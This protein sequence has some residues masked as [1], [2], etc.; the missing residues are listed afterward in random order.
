MENLP[1]EILHLVGN[2]LGPADIAS[3]C[4]TSRNLKAKSEAQLYKSLK[5]TVSPMFTQMRVHDDIWQPGRSSRSDSATPRR[6]RQ[7]ERSWNPESTFHRRNSA[8][9]YV[10][11]ISLDTTQSQHPDSSIRLARSVLRYLRGNRLRGF[12]WA[13][14]MPFPNDI[15]L[16][17]AARHTYLQHIGLEY[18]GAKA[19]LV[20]M[21][22]DQLYLRRIT[23]ISLRE[24]IDPGCQAELVGRLENVL[25]SIPVLKH[26]SLYLQGVDRIPSMGSLTRHGTT[27]ESLTVHCRTS[28]DPSTILYW[29]KDDLRSLN[30]YMRTLQAL[31]CDV[32]WSLKRQW[33]ENTQI[34]MQISNLK[35]FCTGLSTPWSGTPDRLRV[36][37]MLMDEVT[38]I[39]ALG[40]MSP[41]TTNDSGDPDEFI[42]R[43]K[44]NPYDNDYHEK[45][46][47]TFNL[48]LPRFPVPQS[49]QDAESTSSEWQRLMKG[50]ALSVQ[51][52]LRSIC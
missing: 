47:P 32:D 33:A 8:L 21:R 25:D 50:H 49:S 30:R 17:L 44:R 20:P 35:E 10:Q 3:L 18:H 42:F 45:N 29:S 13:S 2:M 5:I 51:R 43:L 37:Q 46:D 14:E 36:Y 6:R 4:A 41:L 48:T 1:V 27:L 52:R 23:S 38:V 39:Q 34:C 19:T 12:G 22:I 26:V 40:R 7:I 11:H 16:E 31:S 15:L 24:N 9:Q 28:A